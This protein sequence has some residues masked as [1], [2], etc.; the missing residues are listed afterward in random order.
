MTPKDVLTWL[1]AEASEA[2]RASLARYGIPTE[3]ALGV[4]MGVMKKQAKAWGY[5]HALA[6]ELWKDGG[7]EART[8]AAH[9]ADPAELTGDRMDAWTADFDNWAICDTCCYQLFAKATPRWEKV[10]TWAPEEEEF[11]KRAAFALIWALT[12]HDKNAPDAAFTATFPLIEAAA[13]DDRPLVHKAVD[14]AL[15]AIGKRNR[16]LNEAATAFAQSIAHTKPGKKALR[17]L[18]S[19]KV[20]A[21]L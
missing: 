18:T 9:L 12:R 5:H 10:K 8:M 13:S 3:G 21:K 6:L 7:Y 4:P 20:R 1:R 11:V 19:E 16:A 15:R 17:E 2:H 14:M